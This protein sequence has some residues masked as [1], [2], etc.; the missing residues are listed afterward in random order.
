M[1]PMHEAFLHDV[2]GGNNS[3]GFKAECV[4]CHLPHDNVANYLFVKARNGISEVAINFLGSPEK[5]NWQEK[6]KDRK[7]FVYDSGCLSC[8]GN[9]QKATTQAGK[10]FLPHRDY[11]AKRTTKTCVECHENVGHKALGLYLHKDK[12]N[13]KEKE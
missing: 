6:R 5:I 12:N 9:L 11:F 13:T 3:V 10:S 2:H 7:H 4:S 8:H 1:K